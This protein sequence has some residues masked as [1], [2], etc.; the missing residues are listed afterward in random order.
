MEL[1]NNA[2]PVTD[3]VSKDYQDLKNPKIDGKKQRSKDCK[4]QR[5]RQPRG[6]N[7][8]LDTKANFHG[9]TFKTSKTEE[10]SGGEAT[11]SNLSDSEPEEDLYHKFLNDMRIFH[12]DMTEETIWET[13]STP[14][15]K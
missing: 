12:P 7:M 3:E 10:K 11:K 9:E 2:I 4:P 13:M 8:V 6:R 1:Q 15:D 14:N 5:D